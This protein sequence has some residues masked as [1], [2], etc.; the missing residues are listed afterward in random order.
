MEK[1]LSRFYDLQIQHKQTME[2]GRPLNRQD[3]VTFTNKFGFKTLTCLLNYVDGYL[4]T[5]RDIPGIGDIP[6][7]QF[8]D[9][10]VEHWDKGYL[11]NTDLDYDGNIMPAVIPVGGA[12]PEYWI[13]GKKIK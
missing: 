7:V 1:T 10:H 6:A 4:Q 5:E 2:H 3:A 13:K 9:G 11:H 8:E 12:E